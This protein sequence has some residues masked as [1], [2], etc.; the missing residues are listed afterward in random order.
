MKK[1]IITMLMSVFLVSCGWADSSRL[2]Q[3]HYDQVISGM[4]LSQVEVL[5]WEWSVTWESV[6]WETDVKVVRWWSGKK[7]V[8]ITFID[9]VV[10]T[11]AQIGVK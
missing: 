6:W 7:F 10:H 4:S 11:K 2:T 8:T 5:L 1:Y 9:D 3:A